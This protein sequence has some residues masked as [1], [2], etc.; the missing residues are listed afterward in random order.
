MAMERVGL[1]ILSITAVT[2]LLVGASLGVEWLQPHL[3]QAAEQ[4][5]LL[6]LV[7]GLASGLYLVAQRLRRKRVQ[8]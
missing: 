5:W 6:L 2:L 4:A 8:N 1:I 3:W 7:A